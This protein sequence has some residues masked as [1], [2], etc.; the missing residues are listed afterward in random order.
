MS[1]NILLI[2]YNI[3][4]NLQECLALIVSAEK[5]FAPRTSVVDDPCLRR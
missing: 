4:F 3:H 2:G 1:N 5:W